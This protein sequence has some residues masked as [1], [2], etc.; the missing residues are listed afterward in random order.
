MFRCQPL[1]ASVFVVSLIVGCA[2]QESAPPVAEPAAEA[3]AAVATTEEDLLARGRY[4][5]EGP[6][7]CLACHSELDWS[8]PGF[9]P[10]PGRRGVGA[11]FPDVSVPGLVVASNITP[12][13]ET[14]IGEW[15]DEEL[16]RAIREGV[17]RDGRRL[18]PAMP[19]MF[20]R[21]L[22][23]DDLAAV[24]AYIR[25]LDPVRNQPP[26]T[27]IPE[28]V[29]ASLPPHQP[30]TEPVPAPDRSDPIAY[31]AYL[32]QI[33]NCIECHTPMTPE[34]HPIMEL[35]LAGGRIMEGPW[36]KVAAP[37]LTTDPSGIPYYTEE[38]FFEVMRTGMVSARDLNDIMIWGYFKDMTD[39]DLGA[40]FAYLQTL[41]PI[42]HRV[43]N[44]E[45]PTPCS[46]CGTSHGLGESNQS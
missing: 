25:T 19:Y 33:G 1:L 43:S 30:I 6:M 9:P 23:D 10:L 42:S 41:E 45:P 32:T 22:S 14:G 20:F 13:P 40:I 2:P 18:F 46:I 38:L 12:D 44:T 31:G 16:G 7:H 11:V 39:D 29:M 26:T 17:G 21:A 36:G 35:M 3:T 24:I 28:P 27:E 8:A 15:T 5:V 34:G 37:N 4:L